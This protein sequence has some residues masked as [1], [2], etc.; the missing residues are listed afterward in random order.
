MGEFK[1]DD[2]TMY[3]IPL[4]F[5][6]QE[7]KSCP[8]C[9][10]EAPLWLTREEWKLTGKNYDFMCPECESVLRVDQA[11]VTGLSFTT[12]SFSGQWKKHK[13]KENRGIYVQVKKIGVHARTMENVPLEGAEVLLPELF[14]LTAAADAQPEE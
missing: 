4:R 10:K 1:R 8:F 9:H 14:A 5:A 3:S 2:K 6:E 7:L 13:G 12:K 11:D